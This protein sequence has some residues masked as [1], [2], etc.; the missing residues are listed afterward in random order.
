VQTIAKRKLLPSAEYFQ[1]R[2]NMQVQ[3]IARRWGS[4]QRL[5]RYRQARR[6]AGHCQVRGTPRRKSL[7]A[8]INASK[9][10]RAWGNQ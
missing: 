6:I 5:W 3:I 9:V 7:S 10:I 4:L 1:V 8:S 2:S